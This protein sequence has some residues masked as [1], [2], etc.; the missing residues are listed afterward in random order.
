MDHCEV[1][2][3][4]GLGVVVHFGVRQVINLQFNQTWDF[5]IGSLV[6]AYMDIF[7]CLL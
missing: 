3:S 1:R 6:S 2:G 5:E 4:T 7:V